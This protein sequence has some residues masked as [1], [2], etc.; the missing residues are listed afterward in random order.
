MRALRTLLLG[1][2]WLVGV[3]SSSFAASGVIVDW[4]NA[5]YVD[6]DDN[7]RGY[8]TPIEYNVPFGDGYTGARWYC[9]FSNT[10]VLTPTQSYNRGTSWRFYGGVLIHSYTNAFAYHWAEIWSIGPYGDQLYYGA[11]EGT[12]GWDLRYWQQPD[13]LA[14]GAANTITFGSASKIEFLNYQG[15]DGVPSNNSGRV[16]AVVRDGSQF[17]ISNAFGGPGTSNTQSFVLIDPGTALW[18]P[19]APAAPHALKFDS[20]NAV[21][22][23][24]TFTNIT[25][26]GYLHSNDNVIAPATGKKAGF[27][28]AQVRVTAEIGTTPPPSSTFTLSRLDARLR[29]QSVNRD[30]YVAKG[31]ITLPAGFSANGQS[32]TIDVGGATRVFTLDARGRAVLADGS[33]VWLKVPGGFAGG[34]VQFSTKAARGNWSN[35]W[36]DEGIDSTAT[37]SGQ[38]LSFPV[39]LSVGSTN[40]SLVASVRYSGTGYKSGGFKLAPVPR[41]ATRRVRSHPTTGAR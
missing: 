10:D 26:V 38:T 20:A 17:W 33:R 37:V 14:G 22:Q 29:F 1:W 35:A 18:A 12:V 30:R 23:S 6:I 24:H 7:V 36:V 2:L 5:N 15:G 4:G 27:T 19:Y 40:A 31:T 13:F 32:L 41:S 8:D 9:P 3:E 25:A 39:Q 21:F 16:R 11:P 34:A 28:C